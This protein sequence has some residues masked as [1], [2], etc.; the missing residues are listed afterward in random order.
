[1]YK[2]HTGLLK[3]I[4][5]REKHG[6]FLIGIDGC[7]GAGKSTVANL[8]FQELHNAQLVHIDD[9]YKT[10]DQRVEVT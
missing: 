7:G 1:M 8:L 5:T 10:K 2:K 3:D 4:F 9:F 6:V